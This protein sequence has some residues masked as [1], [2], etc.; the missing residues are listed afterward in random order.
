MRS[1]RFR[2]RKNLPDFTVLQATKTTQR[3]LL[4]NKL[5]SLPSQINYKKILN[6]KR[7]NI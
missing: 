7:K 4:G 2:G 5:P 3:C 1:G 6:I